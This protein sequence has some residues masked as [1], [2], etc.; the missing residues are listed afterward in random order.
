MIISAGNNLE[1]NKKRVDELNIFPVPDGDTGTNM[2]LTLLTAAK[3]LEQKSGSS[4]SAIADT[5][6]VA[7]LRG[8]RG[9]SGV[10]LSQL[11]RGFA[12][13]LKGYNAINAKVFAQALQRGVNTAYKAVMKPTEGTIL[14]VAREGAKAA[15]AASET[16]D[17]IIVVFEEA[18]EHAKEIL[19]KTPDM[20]PVLKQAGVVDAGGKGLIYILEGALKVLK[21]DEEVQL[22][23][24]NDAEQEQNGTQNTP[25]TI[26]N[27]EFTYCTEFLIMKKGNFFDEINFKRAIE[28]QGDSTLII[29]DND[30]I[31]VHI[32]TNNPGIVIQEA[33]KVG[34]L[35]NIKIDN[36]KEQH[37][38]IVT[39]NT[40]DIL[41]KDKISENKKYGFIAVAVGEGIINV[42]TDLGV[43]KVIKGGQTMNPS[44]EDILKAVNDIQ[45][46]NIFVLANNKNIIPAAEQVK[47]LTNKN[48][49][50]I[51]SK[52][53]P[54]GISAMLA[55]NPELEVEENHKMMVE[56]LSK[57]KTGQVTYAVRNTTIDDKEVLEGDILGIRDGQIN[58]IGKDVNSVCQQLLESLVDEESSIISIFYGHDID[59]QTAE[60]LSEF[61]ENSFPDC[62]VEIHNGD[63]PL[64]YY[65]IAVE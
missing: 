26:D 35:T 11:F 42:F 24:Q 16:D 2:S 14:T 52:S 20:L 37:Q 55:F 43:D 53:I 34:E 38:H 32:H 61:I 44:T 4:V 7:S 19:N 63:Q 3:E 49:I 56:A 58:V 29:N 40:N 18:I 65:I 13:E 51:S 57:V 39:Q 64:Y 59:E 48:I 41:E 17:N 1:N 12:K 5:L 10:I 36:M 47:R 8:A 60:Q 25:S 21:L 22:N 15:V 6:A 30:I 45:A 27:I 23:E 46:K 50:I 62:D 28:A 31:K 33:L 9:N 54:Q